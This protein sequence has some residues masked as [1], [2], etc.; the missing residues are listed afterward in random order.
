MTHWMKFFK[1]Q[2]V[3]RHVIA[4]QLLAILIACLIALVKLVSDQF[5]PAADHQAAPPPEPT[6]AV[7][8]RAW[9]KVEPLLEQADR[10]TAQ[11]LDKH[12][13]AIHAFLDERKAGSRAFAERL[14]SLRGKW[15]LVKAEIGDD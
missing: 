1:D 10:Q 15:E 8:G 9:G 7:R 14:L 11:A 6:S 5:A 3:R 13:A 4:A 2:P 12:L